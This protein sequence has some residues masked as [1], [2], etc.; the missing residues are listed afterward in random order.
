M[1]P[2]KYVIELDFLKVTIVTV[3]YFTSRFIE[4]MEICDGIF[5]ISFLV[6]LLPMQTCAGVSHA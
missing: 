6:L 3:Q 4:V 2:D 1:D 5:F